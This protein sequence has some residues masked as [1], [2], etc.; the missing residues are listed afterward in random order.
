VRTLL[1]AI[2]VLLILCLLSVGISFFAPGRIGWIDRFRIR[3]EKLV[4]AIME[5]RG[6][7]E[8]FTEGALPFSG[9]QPL[10]DSLEPGSLF[11]SKHGRTVSSRFIRGRWKHC[12]I[13]LGTREQVREYW[14]AEH[15]L[16][17]ALLPYYA[18]GDEYLIFDS[19][20]EGGVAIHP[21]GDM[22]GLS[23]ISTL[24]GLLC[25]A[26]GTDPDDWAR[27]ILAGMEHLG[28]DYDYLFDLESAER[29]YC[30]EFLYALL[31][32]VQS[33]L[34]PS[35]KI[36]GRDFLTPT[37]LVRHLREDMRYPLMLMLPS[38]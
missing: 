34:L 19:S 3:I 37:D 15:P 24:R 4:V 32:E 9:L 33:A 35:Q 1:R 21:I 5:G 11:F 13:Y 8:R 12:G 26:N 14:G 23:G 25:F 36:L 16:L 7:R 18:S 29:L 2:S 6:S 17:Q 28:K 38:E 22:A 31:P 20:Y 27:Q 10:L 30:S